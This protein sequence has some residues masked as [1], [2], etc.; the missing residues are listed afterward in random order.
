[1]IPPITHLIPMKA[2]F[3]VEDIISK[4]VLG[5]DKR[6]RINLPEEW[7]GRPVKI[8]WEGETE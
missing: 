7:I 2:W 8:I 6:G 5:Y 1:M 4:K 3:K